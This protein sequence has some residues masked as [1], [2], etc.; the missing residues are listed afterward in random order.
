LRNAYLAIP[1]SERAQRLSPFARDSELQQFID[2]VEREPAQR[3]QGRLAQEAQARQE[4]ELRREQNIREVGP[5]KDEIA[6]GRN[7]GAIAWAWGHLAT[8]EGSRGRVGLGSLVDL[9]GNEF[10]EVFVQGFISFWRQYDP[11]LPEAGKNSTPVLLLAGLTG[12]TF[13][14]QR[15]LAFQSLSDENAR[16]AAT[17]ALYELSGFPLWFNALLASHSEIVRQ[18]LAEAIRAEWATAKEVYGV[19]AK[20]T[21]E[22]GSTAELICGLIIEMLEGGAPAHAHT[23]HHAISVL[24]LSPTRRSEVAQS[25][26]TRTQK[27][28][29]NTDGNLAELLRGWAHFA[30]VEAARWLDTIR[31]QDRL[32]FDGLVMKVA[33]LLEEDFDLR[34]GPFVSFFDEPAG[35]EAW[36]DVL[37]SAVRPEQDIRRVGAYSPGERDRA[38]RFR[39][40]CVEKLASNSSRDAFEA[41]KRV[42]ASRSMAKYADMVERCIE[43]QLQTAAEALATRW[44]EDHVLSVERGDERSPVASVDLFGLVQRHLER[45]ARLL[46]NDDFSY[47]R[48]FGEKTKEAEVQC[49]VGSSL[50]LLS[51]QLYTVER[52]PEV[53]D[54]KEMDISVTVPGVGRVPVEIK[55]LYKSR[56]S[57]AQLERFIERQLVG[58]YM[59]P[60]EVERGI[61]LLVPLVTRTWRVR[62][63]ILSYSDLQDHLAGFANKIGARY[64][65]EVVIASI[66]VAEARRTKGSKT[67]TSAA[68]SAQRKR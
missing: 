4:Q 19:L 57:V 11:P 65:K 15:G 16:R 9:V 8:P 25:L 58:R 39:S 59:R 22:S 18:V 64:K 23:L 13:E 5:N 56:Y 24:L 27:G 48:L 29:Q 42:R 46:E 32:R 1:T 30:P 54:D 50:K 17:Y 45:V 66:N 21:Q 49:W 10:A 52:E 35:L 60:P 55:P 3:E 38:Q 28:A 40:R 51:R 47:A 68:K 34:R 12:L 43:V 31:G 67:R 61:F 41:L 33:S 36:I 2:A 37:H 53:Q 20:S 44:P 26:K 62:S 7:Q 14:A 63:K 6:G